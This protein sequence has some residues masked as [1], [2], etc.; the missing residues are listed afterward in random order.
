ML[1]VFLSLSSLAQVRD[2]PL[3]TP[4]DSLQDQQ[5]RRLERSLGQGLAITGDK[6]SE[7]SLRT[8]SLKQDLEMMAERLDLLERRN[9]ML[10][11]SIASLNTR[12]ERA[13]TSVLRYRKKLHQTLCLAG[14]GMLI[15]TLA[16]FV[17]MWLYSVKS[18]RMLQ[19]LG[20]RFSRLKAAIKAQ[21]KWTLKATRKEVRRGLRSRKRRKR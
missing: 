1:L 16:L 3:S 19:K 5:L 2:A 13:G 9:S 18:R 15:L 21:R 7:T 20:K 4:Y 12:M 17:T 8:D 11:D 10:Q 6:V 14:T